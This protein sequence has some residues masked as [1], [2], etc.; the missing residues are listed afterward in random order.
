MKILVVSG[1]LGA[2]K[3]TFIKSLVKHAG[4]NIVVCEN[5]F[6]DVNIDSD[7]LRQAGAAPDEPSVDALQVFELT[8][9]CICCSMK[10]DFRAS[11]MTIAHAL[12]PEYLIVEPTGV[13]FLGSIVESIQKITYE[14]IVLLK[15]VVVIDAMHYRMQH[16][17][18]A[19]C[20]EDQL[21][22]AHIVV[23]SK[24]QA[25]DQDEIDDLK[26]VIAELNPGAQIVLAHEEQPAEFYQKLLTDHLPYTTS[27]VLTYHDADKPERH[28]HDYDDEHD[29]SHDH[30]HE[31]GHDHGH[32]DHD[33]Q[34]DH[35][36]HDHDHG[37]DHG[38]GH[39]HDEQNPAQNLSS[40][41]VR[42]ITLNSPDDLIYFLDEL[43]SGKYGVIHRSKGWVRCKPQGNQQCYLHFEL[44]GTQ[45][46]IEGRE[47]DLA[48]VE[49]VQ[50]AGS[51]TETPVLSLPQVDCVV[52]G[53]D[54]AR[55][56]I[57]KALDKE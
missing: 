20:W 37:D 19:E 8:E 52:I 25:L 29:H 34:H 57:A 15:A 39:G 17:Q 33:H 41:S 30:D 28:E 43:M 23:I 42:D 36:H 31:H 13:G 12:D 9:G 53:V 16:Q 7:L 50:S 46:L 10:G 3:T 5:E 6:G 26:A 22:N 56:E 35:A 47:V 1:F 55:N 4:H 18:F 11:V 40:M 14:R 21:T 27:G 32:H 44:V 54:L 24:A 49:A 48:Q 51:D 38:H 2:G 45:Y